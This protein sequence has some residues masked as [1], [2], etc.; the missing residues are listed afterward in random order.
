[1]IYVLLL[2]AIFLWFF[3]Y[4]NIKKF[5]ENES[6]VVP[7]RRISAR[8][9]PAPAIRIC[10]VN[11]ETGISWKQTNLEGLTDFNKV[12]N[13]M[14]GK[15]V[16]I[17]QCILQNTYNLEEAISGLSLDGHYWKRF[18]SEKFFSSDITTSPAGQCHTLEGN[19]SMNTLPEALSMGYLGFYLNSSLGYWIT[20]GDPDIF[21]VSLTSGLVPG[22]RIKL[23]A[24]MSGQGTSINI[25]ITEHLHRNTARSPCNGSAGYSLTVCL[26]A[27]VQDRVG[28]SLPWNTR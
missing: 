20:F 4:P 1:M 6:F 16:D 21:Y 3:G 12:Y 14:C 19:V 22:F 28:C 24:N 10:P 8:P 25:R 18:E 27:A 9:I 23:P 7:S 5:L 15:S 26:T 11:P 2:S 13:F 17:S